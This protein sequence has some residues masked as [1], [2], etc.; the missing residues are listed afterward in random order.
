MAVATV[1][2]LEKTL[3]NVAAAMVVAMVAVW[4]LECAGL[5]RKTWTSKSMTRHHC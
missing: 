2:G 1:A 5:Q 3:V 4:S